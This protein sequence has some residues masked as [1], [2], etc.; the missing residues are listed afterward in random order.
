M[1]KNF[2]MWFQND[3]KSQSLVQPW[4]LQ[5]VCHIDCGCL[6][7]SWSSIVE[8]CI[9]TR[10]WS[11]WFIV[12]I[13]IS[14]LNIITTWRTNTQTFV[15]CLYWL[16]VPPNCSLVIWFC[17][18]LWNMLLLIIS[19]STNYMWAIREKQGSRRYWIADRFAHHAWDGFKLV[20][21]V[22]CELS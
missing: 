11:S 3:F 16:I 10:T 19:I 22:L 8:D 5:G 14:Q 1:Q 20:V 12:G 4:N 9:I 18:G 2:E 15:Y 7:L 21:V 17:N 13:N 6:I